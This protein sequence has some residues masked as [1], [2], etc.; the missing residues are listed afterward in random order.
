[1]FFKRNKHTLSTRCNDL[2]RQNL[3]AKSRENIYWHCSRTCLLVWIKCTC[4]CGLRRDWL[5]KCTELYTSFCFMCRFLHVLTA[6]CCH[7]L[8]AYCCH[9]LTA[10]C[11]HVLTAHCCHVLTAHCCHVLTAHCCHVLTAHCCH[12]LTAYCC[13]VLT[14]HCCHVLTLSYI[15]M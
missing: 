5:T 3:V 1:M 14:A 8:T 6:Y 15:Y 13:H 10:Y 2:E 7:V 9:V 11:C 4:I 12:V